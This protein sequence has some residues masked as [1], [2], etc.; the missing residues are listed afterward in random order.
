MYRKYFEEVYDFTNA[1]NYK[2]SNTASGIV[3]NYLSSSSGNTLKDIGIPNRTIDDI[4]KEGLNVNG[5]TISFSLPTG[6]RKYTLCIV[7]D[8]WKNRTFS[9]K[10]KDTNG[11]TLL[12]LYH[13]NLG[14]IFLDV[15]SQRS[16]VS[17]PNT[18]NGKKI[19]IWL[20]EDNSQIITKAKIS[21][22]S[23]ILSIQSSS[24]TNDQNF[25]FTTADGVVY[26]IM[27]STNFYDTDSEQYHKVMLQE[28]LNGSYID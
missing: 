16:H 28:K 15:N 2:L 18:F 23:A 3:F 22:Y 20:A 24:H 13:H 17:L 26:K 25:E 14:S 21:N 6:I 4:K 10:K 11:G 27:F 19:C 8:Y 12:N 7:F 9:I 1:A 5:Y